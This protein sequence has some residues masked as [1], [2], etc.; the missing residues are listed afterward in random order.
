MEQEH[1]RRILSAPVCYFLKSTEEEKALFPD[2]QGWF[3]TA[4]LASGQRFVAHMNSDANAVENIFTLRPINHLLPDLKEIQWIES[5]FIEGHGVKT[6]CKLTDGLPE[7]EQKVYESVLDAKPRKVA[8]HMDWL[9][10]TVYEDHS[11]FQRLKNVQSLRIQSETYKKGLLSSQKELKSLE[12][13]E[14][15]QPV[16]QSSNL[17]ENNIRQKIIERKQ[18]G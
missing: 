15:K 9:A 11:L 12:I 1:I 14:E 18:N 6:I 2:K 7:T 10:T 17:K 13:S 3:Y 5:P 8:T 4:K 16:Q